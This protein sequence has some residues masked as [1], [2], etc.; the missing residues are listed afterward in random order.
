MAPPEL[1]ADTPVLDVVHPLFV[2]V[3]PVLWHKAHLARLHGI[4]RF[5]RDALAR[6]ILGADLVH[7]HEPLVG[8]HRLDHL[9]C[10]GA[11]R[12]H[13]LVLLHL[14]HQTQRLQVGHH[15]FA[16][17]K[18]VQALVG[19]RCLVVDFGVQRQHADHR[20][21]VALADRV[22]VG[23]VRRGNFD[24][25]GAKGPVHIGV[26]NHRDPAAAQRQLYLTA[27]QVGVAFVL[28]VH[29]HSYVAQQGFRAGGGHHQAEC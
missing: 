21:A 25:P 8:Q 20:Q 27:D 7:R 5:L 11:A 22:V 23:V 29:H 17:H 9:A 2:G 12:H 14:H 4:N 28:G 24:D 10:A 1:A 19:G 18:A 6:W 3:D 15:L 13:Q 26:S 16:S